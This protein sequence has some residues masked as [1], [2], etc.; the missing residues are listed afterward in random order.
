MTTIDHVRAISARWW[1]AA[2]ASLG[3]LALVAVVTAAGGRDDLTTTDRVLSVAT[4]AATSPATSTTAAVRPTTPHATTTVPPTSVRPTTTI[5]LSVE[6]ELDFDADDPAI[7]ARPIPID[8]PADEPPP[9]TIAPPPWA[10]STFVTPG[11]QI[12]TDVGCADDR[13]AAALDRFFAERLGPVLGWDYQHV[14][15]LGPDRYLWIFQDAFVDHSGTA[16]TLGASRFV[17]NAALLQNGTCFSLLHRGTTDRPKPFEEGDGTSATRSKWYWP[18]GG[19][20][21]DGQLW[22]FW[23]EMVKDPYDPDPPDGLGWHPNQTLLAAYDAVTLERVAFFPAPNRGVA[24]IYGYAVSSDATHTYLFGNT[25][26]QNLVR[27]GGFWNGPHSATEMW[28]ARVPRGKVAT[29]PEYRTADGW[30][31][32][33]ADAVPIMRRFWAENPMQPRYL[34]GQWVAATSVDGYWGDLLA[35]DVADQPWGPW[36]TVQYEPLLPR[37]ADPKMNTYH[38]HPVPWRDGF[39][40]VIITVSNNARNMVRDAWPS[41]YRYRPMVISSPFTPTPTT[42]TTVPRPKTTTTTSS[43]TT[44]T[45]TT[46]P[47]TT[48]TSPTTA[49]TT[50]SPTTVP[51]TPPTSTPTTTTTAPTST[52]TTATTTTTTTTVA[53]R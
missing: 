8:P 27:E 51:T 18:M 29:A 25:F 11:G 3:V 32:T 20:L 40:S 19:E 10:S 16:T 38:A 14:Y 21:V 48:T 36:T 26:E 9:V 24:P 46:A 50:T 15:P 33:P 39:G 49:P 5:D 52:A 13:S 34:D 22:V 12:S 31:A 44:T 43:T 6:Y 42:T 47:T 41:P 53:G 35:V 2:A 4:S 23:S 17:H 45:T 7:S 1:V 37:G 28:L 30:S